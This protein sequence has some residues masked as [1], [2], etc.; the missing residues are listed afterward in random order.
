ST[1]II[2][3]MIILLAVLALVVVRALAESPWGIVTVGATIPI[4]M[5][6]GCYLRFGRIGKVM[7]AS[8]IGVIL[9]LLAVWAGKFAHQ[10]AAWSKMLG[11]H[12]ITLAW[13]IIGY[14]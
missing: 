11:L 14:G 2:A 9:L 12:D 10:S 4:A 3:I 1:A 6:M 8:A 13:V 7:E 5:F